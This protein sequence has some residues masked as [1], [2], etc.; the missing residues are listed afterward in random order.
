[1][2]FLRGV[3][4]LS[5]FGWLWGSG[6]RADAES[7]ELRPAT[8]HEIEPAVRLML[9]SPSH[10]IDENNVA[11]F[12]HLAQTRRAEPGGLW[13]AVA[14]RRLVSVAMPVVSP[15]R[16]MLI[17]IPADL[18][19]PAQLDCSRRLADLLCAQAVARGV[20]LAQILVEASD[21]ALPARI[22]DWGFN[23][24][25]E[26]I[27][28]QAQLPRT[29]REP[30]LSPQFHWISYSPDTHP[31]F[32][33]TILATYEHSLDCPALN[34][35]RDIDD[36]L[37]GH[38]AT[39][40]FD[41]S[42][43]FVLRH[44]EDPAGVLLLSR[45]PRTDVTELVYLGVAPP[46]RGAG[47]ADALMRRAATIVAHSQHNR[48][49][50]AVDAANLPALKLYWRH[51]LQAVSR[52]IALMRDLRIPSVIVRDPLRPPAAQVEPI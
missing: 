49:S 2:V 42:I 40:Q 45:I 11:S 23:R 20:H 26:L 5:N 50:L 15:G 1:M 37:A 46:F 6:K 7:V 25:A 48:L 24:L 17:F 43:W 16:T 51:G 27:Y 44:G 36:V 38:R 8:E 34:G 22:A 29:V 3:G 35:L 13:I 39:G 30:A 21:P 18:R 19:D 31:L 9:T 33:Q 52:K 12:I 32:T 28:L 14:G 10:G 4:T 47:I 41:A